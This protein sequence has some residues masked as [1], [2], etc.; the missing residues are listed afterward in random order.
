MA[1]LSGKKLYKITNADQYNVG[2]YIRTGKKI[3]GLDV[4]SFQK[5]RIDEYCE[6]MNLKVK[7]YYIDEG[8]GMFEE[9][10]PEYERLM[11]DIEE[12]NIN[13]IV[14]A[15]LSRIA[16]THSEMTEVLNRQKV[17]GFRTLFVDSSEELLE[18]KMKVINIED[19]I[20]NEEDFEELEEYE[21]ED[22][23]EF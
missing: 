21:E 15:N 2:V 4:V 16:R 22:D 12:G 10:K 17:Y 3:E 23:M 13:M 18:D 6:Y 8:I 9:C 7:D 14:T 5:D 1:R 20:S 11:Q 19:Y